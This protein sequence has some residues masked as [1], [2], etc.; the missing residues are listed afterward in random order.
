MDW[1][2]WLLVVAFVLLFIYRRATAGR[3][4]NSQLNR[5]KAQEFLD[6]NSTR[7]GVIVTD[8]GLQLEVLQMGTGTVHPQ[9]H[10]RVLV[11]YVGQLSNGTVFDSSVARNEPVAFPLN[12][13][14]RGWTEGLQL[15]VEGEK[16][17]LFIPPDLGYGDQDMGV[18]PPGSLLIFD[19][20]LLKIEA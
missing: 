20:E 17:R 1:I 8:S 10:D 15:M 3:R 2:I 4:I 16:V 19:V 13:V 12:R 7:V 6:Q 14:I 11:H 18:I 5:Q 9:E